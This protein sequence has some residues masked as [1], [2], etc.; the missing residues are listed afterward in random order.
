MIYLNI[1]TYEKFND[2]LER[3]DYLSYIIYLEIRGY[4]ST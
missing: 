1:L 2:K 4:L 3:L